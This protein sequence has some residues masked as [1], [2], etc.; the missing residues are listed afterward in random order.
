MPALEREWASCQTTQLSAAVRHRAEPVQRRIV[1]AKPDRLREPS[2]T[3]RLAADVITAG[4]FSAQN[5][6][7]SQIV[8]GTLSANRI[9]GGILSGAQLDIS[10]PSGAGKWILLPV[11]T[12][13]AI[14]TA[15]WPS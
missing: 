8:T 11:S 1:N 14:S 15:A 7:A 6:N 5:I 10:T 3:A 13:S 4:N 2:A 9:Y 12:M